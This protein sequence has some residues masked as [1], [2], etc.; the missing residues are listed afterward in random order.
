MYDMPD[1]ETRP[2]FPTVFKNIEQ[3]DA[4]LGGT[5]TELNPGNR[6]GHDLHQGLWHLKFGIDALEAGEFT[7]AAKAVIA[8]LQASVMVSPSGTPVQM[9]NNSTLVLPAGLQLPNDTRTLVMSVTEDTPVSIAAG[10]GANAIDTGSAV[11]NSVYYLWVIRNPTT[12]QVAG[13]LSLSSTSPILPSGYTQKQLYPVDFQTETVSG[14]VRFVFKKLTSHQESI[15]YLNQL[16]FSGSVSSSETSPTLID[17]NAKFG[18]NAV[19][20]QAIGLDTSNSPYAASFYPSELANQSSGQVLFIGGVGD[21]NGSE[22][23][24]NP[25]RIYKAAR[26]AGGSIGIYVKSVKYGNLA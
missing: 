15:F 16:L 17:F 22:F 7:D 23:I 8:G 24:V 25:S 6:P 12:E 2:A 4:V 20:F 10:N 1:Y 14:N 3:T 18:V 26:G 21:M 19:S 5:Q 11:T 13:L 9:T